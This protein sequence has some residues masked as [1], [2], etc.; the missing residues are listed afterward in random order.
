MDCANSHYH[1]NFHVGLDARIVIIGLPQVAEQLKADAEQAI[2]ITQSYILA[3]TVMLLLI[4]RLSDIFGRVRIYS[5]GFAVFTVGSALTSLGTDPYQVIAFRA[6]Q[7]F[8]ASLIFANSIAIVTDST[9]KRQLGLFVGINQIAYRAGALLGLTVSG[10]IL[11]FLDWR[12]LFY[13]NIPV[14]VFG[15]IWARRQLKETAQL[16]PNTKIDWAGFLAFAAFLL[17]LMMAL[18]FGGYG[19]TQILSVYG[20]M[21]LSAVA[22]SAFVFRE[23]RISYPLL[24]FRLF[25]IKQVTG[26][27]LAVFL[28]VVAWATVLLLLSLQFQLIAG[29]TPL[30]A[31]LRIL[32]FEIAFLAVGPLSGTLSDRFGYA[33]F[34]VSGLALGS[35]ALFL[36]STI[37]EATSYL[38]L[39]IYMA[40]LGV[41]TGLFLA[42]NLRGVMGA[43]PMERRGVGSAVVTLFLNVG[44]AV[45]LNLAIVVMS[46]TAPYDLITRIVS[47]V[48][49]VAISAA[50]K[51]L[52]FESIKGTYLVV[53]IINAIAI[54][55]SLLR[56]EQKPKAIKPDNT[57]A[58]VVE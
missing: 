10:I 20:L 11:S 5:Y 36:F 57:L 8:G 1:R 43:L 45:S 18:T 23:R 56:F 25:R 7:G 30:Q 4:G 26:G 46:F 53:A 52:F 39:S 31:G 13:I 21:A 38:V 16:D 27:V 17:S 41:G 44:L 33:R 40:L 2:W 51:L 24:D 35:V 19:G 42:P 48:N 47:S 28:N 50:D 54:V 22:F 34:T 14:G 6:V 3:V 12:A 9:P 58:V 37:T 49:P 55:P 32:P 29:E 15:T